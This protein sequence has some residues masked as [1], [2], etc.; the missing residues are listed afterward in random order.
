MAAPCSDARSCASS[1]A[2]Q[3]RVV[4]VSDKKEKEALERSEKKHEA[5]DFEAKFKELK[6]VL[7]AEPALFTTVWTAIGVKQR[8]HGPRLYK[9]DTSLG[10]LAHKHRLAGVVQITKTDESYFVSLVH[11]PEVC[12]CLLCVALNKSKG[13]KLPQ[14]CMLL[15]DF[16]EWL[17]KLHALNGNKMLGFKPRGKCV[18]GIHIGAVQFLKP[19][20]GRYCTHALLEGQK[21]ALPSSPKIDFFALQAWRWQCQDNWDIKAARMVCPE[22]EESYNV[23]K[24]LF[25]GVRVEARDE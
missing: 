16:K 3:Q 15:S 7:K 17:D 13:F 9:G 8:V 22:T 24:K 25:K 21:H 14:K 5:Q 18:P 2:G 1:G 4:H 12:L 20:T 10:T 6:A 11:W 19:Q 23:M